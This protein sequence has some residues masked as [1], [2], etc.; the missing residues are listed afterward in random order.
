MAVTGVGSPAVV[1]QAVKNSPTKAE[2]VNET[3]VAAN[4]AV[5][6]ANQVATERQASV[7]GSGRSIDI[8]A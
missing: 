3:A 6:E 1:P 2:T 4:A 8:L 5:H 7:R